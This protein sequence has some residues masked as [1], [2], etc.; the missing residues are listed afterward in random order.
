MRD[1]GVLEQISRGIYRLVELPPI[2]NP[3][4]VTVSLRFP[5][6]VICL[7][8]ALY[9]HDLTTEIPRSI[10]LAIYRNAHIPRIDYPPVS[11]YRMSSKPFFAGVEQMKIGGVTMNIFSPEK[12]IADCFKYRDKLGLDLAVEGKI[13]T[14]NHF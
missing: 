8:S 4:L 11:F 5:D 9:H 7:I 14:A 2:S 13:I 10:H 6:A 3:D 12:T 1:N